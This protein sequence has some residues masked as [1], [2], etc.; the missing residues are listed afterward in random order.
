M[1]TIAE[2]QALPATDA[3]KLVAGSKV[4]FRGVSN[5]LLQVIEGQ[6][7]FA[8]GQVYTVET[9][10]NLLGLGHIVKVEGVS[11]F[12]FSNLFA[13]VPADFV[14]P[15]PVE[16]ADVVVDAVKT[17]ET[18]VVNSDAGQKVDAVVTAATTT[19]EDTVTA[20]TTI[21]PVV[22]EAVTAVI[23]AVPAVEAATTSPIEAI[24][25][26]AT[27][28]T[29]VAA[30]VTAVEQVAPAVEADVQATVDAAK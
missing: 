29:D 23:D 22:T 28:T 15:T 7:S 14:A 10:H 13:D 20:A 6:K 9:V 25:A 24:T 2:I 16:T 1:T 4:V 5:V 18:E 19:V 17:A 30:A 11:G 27:A 12:H 26:V 3:S 21:A 8:L